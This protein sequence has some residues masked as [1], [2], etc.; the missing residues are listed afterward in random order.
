MI[1]QPKG[2]GPAFGAILSLILTVGIFVISSYVYA[3]FSVIAVFILYLVEFMIIGMMITGRPFGI[4]INEMNVMSLSRF[5]MSLWTVV[6]LSGYTVAVLLRVHDKTITSAL[7]LE[8]DWRVWALLGVSAT[9]MVGAPMVNSTKKLEKPDEKTLVKASSALNRQSLATRERG[10][11]RQ[12]G[13]KEIDPKK[14]IENTSEGL[15]Y[16]KESVQDAKFTDIFKGDQINNAASLD[17]SKVQMFFFSV[18]I[19]ISYFVSLY[20]WIVDNPPAVLTS[21]PTVS[22][23]VLAVL[24]ISATGYLGWKGINWS[25]PSK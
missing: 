15:I 1:S 17:I 11:Q 12:E 19:S 5:Q 9:S 4:L 20:R 6:V 24:G 3:G 8:V 18:V 16:G 22:D 10:G 13:N 7:D 23:G 14:S 2:I 21:F 25:T